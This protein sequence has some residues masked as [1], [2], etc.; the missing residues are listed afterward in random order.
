[1]YPIRVHISMTAGRRGCGISSTVQ[2][3]YGGSNSGAAAGAFNASAI[4]HFDLFPFF[5][6]MAAKPAA[7]PETERP[8]EAVVAQHYIQ[9]MLASAASIATAGDGDQAAVTA[10]AAAVAT[11]ASQP[12]PIEISSSSDGLGHMGPDP[13]TAIDEAKNKKQHKPYRYV[14][15]CIAGRSTM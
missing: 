5:K 4:P 11:A 15:I 10:A 8:K 9:G 7:T 13:K 14:S 2:G 1:M 12:A 6:G 3:Y